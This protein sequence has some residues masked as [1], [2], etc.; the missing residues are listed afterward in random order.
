MKRILT[1]IVA[2]ATVVCLAVTVGASP[3]ARSSTTAEYI[4]DSNG[5][6]Y[7]Y[8]CSM[9]HSGNSVYV[10]LSEY[11]STSGNSYNT[12]V[13][14]TAVVSPNDTVTGYAHAAAGSV[15]SNEEIPFDAYVVASSGRFMVNGTAVA[16]L[17]GG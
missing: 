5:S 7:L 6:R 10:T 17:Y 2:L 12:Q 13:N 16:N 14:V 3:M 9:Y 8:S 4:D 11:N 15:I 1:T